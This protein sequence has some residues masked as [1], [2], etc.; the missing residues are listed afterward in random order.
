MIPCFAI[1]SAVF[2]RSSRYMF[3]DQLGSKIEIC[4]RVCPKNHMGFAIQRRTESRLFKELCRRASDKLP[5]LP[6]L[7]ATKILVDSLGILKWWM[8]QCENLPKSKI[9]ISK[10][11]QLEEEEIR[12]ENLVHIAFLHKDHPEEWYNN[13]STHGGSTSQIRPEIV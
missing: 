4:V 10:S 8:N 3:N 6:N 1:R 5:L 2:F 11:R 13:Y 9:I 12:R 7:G